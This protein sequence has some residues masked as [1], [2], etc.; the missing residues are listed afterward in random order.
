MDA[1]LIL[2]LPASAKVA[3]PPAPS[4]NFEVS[5]LI[6]G[7]VSFLDVPLFSLQDELLVGPG[8]LL[9]GSGIQGDERKLAT[10]LGTLELDQRQNHRDPSIQV[11]RPATGFFQDLHVA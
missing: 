9:E 2:I 5:V 7:K 1:H 6:L 3:G 11:V 10:L 8:Q 4:A